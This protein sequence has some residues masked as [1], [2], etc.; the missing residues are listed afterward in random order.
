MKGPWHAFFVNHEFAANYMLSTFAR[1]FG[2]TGRPTRTPIQAM[3]CMV[4]SALRAPAPV[5]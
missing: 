1:T 2:L 4:P 3:A 5:N